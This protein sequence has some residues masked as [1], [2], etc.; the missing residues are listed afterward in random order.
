MSDSAV[1]QRGPCDTGGGVDV[2]DGDDYVGWFGVIVIVT[3]IV[4]TVLDMLW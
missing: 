3:V 1:D 2:G 4:V